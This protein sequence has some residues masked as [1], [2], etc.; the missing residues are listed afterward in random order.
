LGAYAGGEPSG[1]YWKQW[2]SAQV[3]NGDEVGLL[4]GPGSTQDPGE[5]R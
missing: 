3:A 4:G 2:Y 1:V 5:M